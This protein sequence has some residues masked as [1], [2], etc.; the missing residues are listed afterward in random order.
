MSGVFTAKC[1]YLQLISFRFLTNF[2][3]SHSKIHFLDHLSWNFYILPRRGS[4]LSFY[5]ELS[6][7]PFRLTLFHYYTPENVL[8]VLLKH[9]SPAL[10]LV[11]S[12]NIIPKLVLFFPVLL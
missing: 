1:L 12:R 8:A 3:K 10:G 9:V 7:L 4:F 6:S 2:L 11:I 5:W